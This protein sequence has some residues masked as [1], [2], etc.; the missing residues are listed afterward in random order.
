MVG[1]PLEFLAGVAKGAERLQGGDRRKYL[2]E[3]VRGLELA[4]VWD[5][6]WKSL[7]HPLRLAVMN[8]GKEVRPFFPPTSDTKVIGVEPLTKLEEAM[9][10][11]GTGAQEEQGEE[12][13]PLLTETVK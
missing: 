6:S 13:P 2:V 3:A 9:A 4:R 11:R 12:Q 1:V 7:Q 10:F 8:E 5:G